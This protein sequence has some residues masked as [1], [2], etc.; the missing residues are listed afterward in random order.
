MKPKLLF[1]GITMSRLN[2]NFQ[3]NSISER[4]D[5]VKSYLSSIKFTPT[6]DELEMCANYILWGK[7]IDGLNV[8]QRK[9]IEIETK[10]K[11]WIKNNAESLEELMEN[12]AF[13]EKLIVP[14]GSPR[15]KI[16]RVVFNREKEL[17][18][19]PEAQKAALKD[20]FNRI[21][22][23]DLMI[24]FYEIKHGKRKNPPRKELLNRFT[25]ERQCQIKQKSEK[26]N[27]F[28]YLK[29]RHELVE[30]RS[31]QYTIKD[32]YAP[33]LQKDL[34]NLS[35][36]PDI[37]D[38]PI[39]GSEFEVFPLG[40]YGT[41]K[42]EEKIFQLINPWEL[43]EEEQK[44]INNF[45]WEQQKLYERILQSKCI[46]FLDFRNSEHLRELVLNRGELEESA[47]RETALGTT[48][49]LL[50][51]FDFYIK[52]AKLE[53]MHREILDLKFNRKKNSEISAIINQK[54]GKSYTDNYI[55]TI[56]TQKILK[57]ISNA[58][59][60]HEEFIGNLPFTENFK[61]CNCC[62]KILLKSPENFIR[63]SNSNDGFTNRCKRCDK[64]K[65]QGG[66]M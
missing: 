54:Y 5:F 53:E 12:P 25:E 1:R 21:D 10:H 41:K 9:E 64:I 56:F 37:G 55:S 61:I 40:L 15:I 28:Q 59:K 45:Y 4:S 27:Q 24:E 50:R 31:E 62:G 49:F 38:K 35:L 8:T 7:D 46:K 51:T 23:I 60:Q 52:Q 29:F 33:Q 48:G 65:R 58:A 42:I 36:P 63:K 18:R 26:L 20:L 14:F 11:T 39:F 6:S 57:S 19:A 44:E 43:K 30:L 2:L 32:S 3:L 22:S 66:K 47:R 34:V 13:N 17:S 16:P